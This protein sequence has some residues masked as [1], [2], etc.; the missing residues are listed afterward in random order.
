MANAG[1]NQSDSGSFLK[2]LFGNCTPKGEHENTHK[3]SL[4][5]AGTQQHLVEHLAISAGS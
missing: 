1:L 4:Y 2:L 5:Q 3:V